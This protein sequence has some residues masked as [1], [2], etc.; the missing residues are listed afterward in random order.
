MITVKLFGLLR[1]ESGIREAALEAATVPEMKEALL[2]LS[3]RITRKDLEGCVIFINGRPAKKRSTLS[4][5][6][7]VV[8]MS[9]V[10]GG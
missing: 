6:D 1:L 2:A 4:D 5:G 10:A 9:P 7:Q 8:L 3:D